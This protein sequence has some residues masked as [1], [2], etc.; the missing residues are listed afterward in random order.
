[1]DH[2]RRCWRLVGGALVERTVEQVIPALEQNLVQMETVLE[3]M[4]GQ[5]KTVE[6]E[7]L[8][9]QQQLGIAQEQGVQSQGEVK[10]SGVLVT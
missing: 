9:L 7:L 6:R 8:Q 5:M 1:M 3:R 2:G 4:S 10:T